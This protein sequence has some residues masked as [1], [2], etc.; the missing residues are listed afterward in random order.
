MMFAQ[1][2]NK[3]NQKGL[4]AMKNFIEEFGF[5]IFSVIA[6]MCIVVATI[7]RDATK[8][9]KLEDSIE[10][11]E[12]LIGDYDGYYVVL[13]TGDNNIFHEISGTE[14]GDDI[15]L[16]VPSSISDN[17]LLTFY[18]SWN[19]QLASY[20]CDFKKNPEYIVKN[21]SI[22]MVKS[23]LPFVYIDIDKQ[24]MERV[25]SSY[26]NGDM[27]KEKA[28]VKVYIDD[29]VSRKIDAGYLSP[30]GSATWNLY[31]KMPYSLKLHSK[32]DNEKR[33]NL[34]ANATDKTLLKNEIFFDLANSLDMEYTP[35]IGNV[36][37]YFNDWYQGVYS[38]ST[39]VRVGKNTVDLSNGDFLFCW[40]ASRPKNVIDYDCNFWTSDVEIKDLEDSSFID[41]EWPERNDEEYLEYV[42][43]IVQTYVDVLE[44]RSDGRLS[45][46]VDLESLAK[47][48]WVQEIGMNADGWYRST[49]SYYKQED[50]KIHYGPLWDMEV[51]LGSNLEKDDSTF[52]DPC[53]WCLRNHGYYV[54]LFKNKE[55]VD[56]VNRV[57]TDYNIEKLMYDSYDNYVNK[58]NALSLEGEIN[59]QMWVDENNFFDI[60]TPAEYPTYN[61]YCQAKLDFYKTRIDWIAN[62]MR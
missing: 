35:K 61:D 38:I 23:D 42:Q 21:R 55:F 41:L 33:F 62:E 22:S 51:T 6:L 11:I 30:R 53:G 19:E 48:Y 7:Y 18:T 24:D 32:Y 54:P 9:P 56:E 17:V 10:E 60:I 37:M 27:H 15:V 44:G 46:Y 14:I 34:L 31:K 57:Y 52:L 25:N 45:D 5:I 3:S 2:N 39:K 50:G 16:V 29:R 8:Y 26:R 20:K 49:Y 12:G 58:V 1:V 47:Y 28:V 40:G 4:V 43:N 59:Y 13:H 36:N